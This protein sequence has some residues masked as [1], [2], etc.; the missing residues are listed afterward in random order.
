MVKKKVDEFKWNT[1]RAEEMLD[2]IKEIDNVIAELWNNIP[3]FWSNEKINSELSVEWGRRAYWINDNISWNTKI[4]TWF[5]PRYIEAIISSDWISS[6]KAF[7]DREGKLQQFCT[8]IYTEN[9]V[10]GEQNVN[11]AKI[12]SMNSLWRWI[13]LVNFEMDWF[14]VNWNWKIAWT[15]FE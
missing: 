14:I 6:G 4:N 8:Y 11:S 7:L 10:I 3:W 12:G 1:T 13:S 2:Q 15:A 5:L 9:I